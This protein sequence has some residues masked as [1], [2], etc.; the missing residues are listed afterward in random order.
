MLNGRQSTRGY[1]KRKPGE[2]IL[3]EGWYWPDK[4]CV[5]GHDAPRNRFKHCVECVRDCRARKGWFRNVQ[6]EQDNKEK[7]NALRR[8]WAV[9]NPKQYLVGACKKAA[10]EKGVPFDLTA[11][12]FE[13]PAVCPVLGIA[14]AR[15]TKDRTDA[16]PSLDRIIPAKGYVR[17]N[18]IVVSWRANRIKHNA[19]VAELRR[20][21]DFYQS[22]TKD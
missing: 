8:D 7:R 16:S 10:K 11:D 15:G 9:R 18:V 21:A 4:L 14:L 2:W 20:V 22:I 12:D 1:Q 17:G 6:W 3:R 13:I 5:K 19:S